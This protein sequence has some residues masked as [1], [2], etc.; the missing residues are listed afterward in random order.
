MMQEQLQSLHQRIYAAALKAQRK[1]ENIL[2]LAVSKQ[3]SSGAIRQAFHLGL[4]HFGE[5]YYQEAISK[6]AELQDLPLIWHFIGPIQSNKTKGIAQNF[7]W[8]HSI[9]RLK[10]ASLLNEYRG[11]A[12]S[13]LNV[14]LQIKLIPEPS[15]AGA[16]PKEAFELV[17]Q[18]TKLRNL[19]LRGLMVIPPPLD[20]Y[21]QQFEIF[22]Q[23]HRLLKDLNEQFHL[24]MDT[25]SMG[26]SDDLDSAI[27][28]GATI[29]RIG[30]ALFGE[31]QG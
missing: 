8:V 24:S 7:S 20:D 28:A 5:N 22:S 2:L 15:K 21:D 11:S 27:A 14:C 26:M 12:S 4:K 6:I 16:S 29:I 9:D 31:R 10:I 23:L 17:E 3:Q 1:P 19:N 13:P 25:L 30:R 18:I